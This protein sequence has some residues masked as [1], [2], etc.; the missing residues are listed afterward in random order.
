MMSLKMLAV[1]PFVLLS[2]LAS[3]S[4]PKE[5]KAISD[6]CGVI[7]RTLYP[8]GKFSFTDSEIDAMSEANQIKLDSVKRFYRSN[9]LKTT[10]STKSTK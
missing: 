2:P 4:V 6:A 1:A 9:C 5:P 3:C 7:Q 10:K 8:D